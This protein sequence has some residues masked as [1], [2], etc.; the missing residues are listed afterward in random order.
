[1]PIFL[2]LFQK[3]A[4]EGTLQNSFYEATSILLPKSNKDNTKNENYM[5]ISLLNIDAK[6]LKK[7]FS[8]QNSATHQK[9]HTP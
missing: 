8:K 1:M 6:I 3:C 2:K 7:I 4:E 5:L 9:A